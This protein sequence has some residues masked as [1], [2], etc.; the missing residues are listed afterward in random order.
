MSQQECDLLFYCSYLVSSLRAHQVGFS[1]ESS[2]EEMQLYFKPNDVV[3]LTWLPREVVPNYLFTDPE[4]IRINV[5]LFQM[6]D[7]PSPRWV[8]I[9]DSLMSNLDNSGLAEFTVPGTVAVE[10]CLDQGM[11]CPVAFNVSAVDG[12]MV[13]VL[14][15]DEVA[16]PSGRR[17]PETGIWSSIAYLQAS[18]INEADLSQLC[19]SW[20]SPPRPDS[21]RNVISVSMLSRLPACPPMLAQAAADRRYR[22]QV[23]DPGF[24]S[25]VTGYSKAARMFYH[26]S[27]SVCYLE[28]VMDARCVQS[29]CK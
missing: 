7:R 4:N 25:H 21:M 27:A 14:G 29:K 8:P 6:V 20:A 11:I 16:L 26:P 2:S 24:S 10:D 1:V 23:M 13:R 17:T 3:T 5:Q 15:E 19:A 12:T 28:V 9:A 22:R 18:A